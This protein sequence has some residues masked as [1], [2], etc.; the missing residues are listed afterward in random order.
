MRDSHGGPNRPV[1][2]DRPAPDPTD[3][4]LS[5]FPAARCVCMCVCMCVGMCVSVSVCVGVCLG[6]CVC[7]CLCVIHP[8]RILG[9][10]G[11]TWFPFVRRT[12]RATVRYRL[13]VDFEEGLS[14][15][16]TTRFFSLLF[17]FIVSSGL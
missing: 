11:F 8:S 1:S 12:V 6:V 7:V 2:L 10:A 4:T 16:R 13:Q 9:S 14:L 15:A 17:F 5:C 3:A